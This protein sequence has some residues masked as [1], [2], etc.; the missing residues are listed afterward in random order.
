[1]KY[2]IN[3]RVLVL[4]QNYQPLNLCTA[5]RAV[6][7]LNVGKAELLENGKGEIRTPTLSFPIPSVIRLF[8]MVKKPLKPLRL[9]RKEVF[10]RDKYACIYC[11]KE[12]PQLT[13][14]H[15]L[16]RS[17]GGVNS[18]E[19]VVSACM[20]CNHRKAGRTPQEAG[21]RLMK[22]VKPPRLN[23]YSLFLNK[24]LEENWYKFIPWMDKY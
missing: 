21:M 4:N 2:R 16:P 10:S 8:L 1:M 5:R 18:W 11:G 15:V 12:T 6:V 19:N 13:L 20:T 3:S 9:S 14:D 23:P 7:L 24:Q 17:R 22:E